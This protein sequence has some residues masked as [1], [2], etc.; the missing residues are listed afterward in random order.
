MKIDLPQ[1]LQGGVETRLSGS[2]ILVLVLVV[3]GHKGGG[4]SS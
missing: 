2:Y 3:G 1:P 4:K